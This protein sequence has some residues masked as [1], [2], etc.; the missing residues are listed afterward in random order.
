MPGL[1]AGVSVGRAL[2]TPTRIYVKS[3][4]SALNTH[5]TAIKGLAHITGGGLV[6]NIPRMLPS[7]L[8][9]QVD[10]STWAQPSVFSWLQRAGNV[11]SAE[12]AR[13][14]NCGVGMIIAVDPASEAAIRQTFEAAGEAVYRVGELRVRDAG[15]EGCVLSGLESWA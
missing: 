12:M 15:E 13:A 14:F 7:T 3:I 1:E 4:L 2:L 6:E 5:G 9:A 8:T 10:V 11:S